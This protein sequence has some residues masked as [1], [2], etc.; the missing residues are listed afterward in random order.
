LLHLQALRAAGL[1]ARERDVRAGG[2]RRAAH[3][4]SI[5]QIGWVAGV[6]PAVWGVG[7]IWTGHW[8]DS[9]G[10]KALIVSGMLIEA[11]ALSLLA[12]SDGRF[13][14]AL[15]AAVVLGVGTALVY[16]T[17]IAAVSDA[18]SPVA[19]APVVGVYRFWRD[20]GYAAGEILPWL[21]A[22]GVLLAAGQTTAGLI[23]GAML[24]AACGLLTERTSASR[25]PC[26]A[27]GGVGGVR[28]PD[29]GVTTI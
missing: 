27:S 12:A 16:P 18:V 25:R 23:L 15:A 20:M 26:S 22:V 11:G 13:G 8:S 10:R 21:L 17:L 9:V 29:P 5:G 3:G 2:R 6:Y 24:L 1:V 19:R 7:Q 14:A 4:A 28:P